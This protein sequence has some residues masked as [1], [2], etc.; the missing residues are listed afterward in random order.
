[1]LLS[2]AL[3]FCLHSGPVYSSASKL[4]WR[5]PPALCLID[6]DYCT[7]WSAW[8]SRE[9]VA[10]DVRLFHTLGAERLV[11]AYQMLDAHVGSSDVVQ[12]TR[13]GD[14]YRRGRYG[15]ELAPRRVLVRVASFVCDD[16]RRRT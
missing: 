11:A 9:A 13:C 2:L 4:W 1:M 15:L 16:C 7:R 14:Q 8:N 5:T 12:C 6:P 10:V 3:A